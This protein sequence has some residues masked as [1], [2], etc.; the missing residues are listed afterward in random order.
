MSA[1]EEETAA[2]QTN[3]AAGE[4]EMNDLLVDKGYVGMFVPLKQAHI[5]SFKLI[6]TYFPITFILLKELMLTLFLI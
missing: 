3:N 1:D 6:D 5:K 2:V 4:R